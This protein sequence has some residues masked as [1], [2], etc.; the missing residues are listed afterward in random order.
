MEFSP[1]GRSGDSGV[2]RGADC[3]LEELALALMGEREASSMRGAGVTSDEA[4]IDWGRRCATSAKSAARESSLLVSRAGAVRRGVRE[5]SVAAVARRVLLLDEAVDFDAAGGVSVVGATA[6]VFDGD[7]STLCLGA[8][9]DDVS[10]GGGAVWVEAD[11]GG[12]AVLAGGA[13]RVLVRRPL[14]RSVRWLIESGTAADWDH[15]TE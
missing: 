14:G 3:R 15:A 5:A 12:G 1:R 13:F 4:E 10:G 9:A 7:E 11:A 8:A 2:V 6:F